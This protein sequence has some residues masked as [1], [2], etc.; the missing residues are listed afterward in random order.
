[1]MQ[2]GWEGKNGGTF[3]LGMIIQKFQFTRKTSQLE[4]DKEL[5]GSSKE[6]MLMQLCQPIII[7]SINVGPS[8]TSW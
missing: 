7:V 5:K 1:M 2:S 8:I 4:I 6:N 3:L